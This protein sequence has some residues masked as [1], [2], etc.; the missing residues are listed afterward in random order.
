MS[1]QTFH[2]AWRAMIDESEYDAEGILH[3][4]EDSMDKFMEATGGQFSTTSA[5]P[6]APVLEWEGSK[7][8][9]GRHQ[10]K[11]GGWTIREYDGPEFHLSSPGTD[12]RFP[13]SYGKFQTL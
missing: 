5:P 12:Y 11:S 9:F 1:D 10:W 6:L 4:T 8:D 7:N 13:Q 3:I 2:N